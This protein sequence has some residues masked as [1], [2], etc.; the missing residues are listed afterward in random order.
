MYVNISWE[1][2]I[3][4]DKII[5]VFKKEIPHIKNEKTLKR[6]R[7]DKKIKTIVLTDKGVYKIPIRAET[8]AY[9][10][11]RKAGGINGRQ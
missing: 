1:E 2:Y 3:R 6:V 11:N 7:Y 10:V 8:I 4:L 9:R 5:G